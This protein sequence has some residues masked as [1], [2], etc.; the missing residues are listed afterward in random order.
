MWN[1]D[2]EVP[3]QRRLSQKE[4]IDLRSPSGDVIKGTSKTIV[5]YLIIAI[6][7]FAPLLIAMLIKGY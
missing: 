4:L 1:D 6:V 2:H 5:M 7:M 3:A